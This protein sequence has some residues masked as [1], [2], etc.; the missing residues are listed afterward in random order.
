MGDA[1][2][3][4][5]APAGVRPEDLGFGVL[6]WTMRDAA[7]VGDALTGTIVLWNPAAERLFGW[8][9][10]E[11]VGRPLELLIPDHLRG[12]HRAGL[13]RFAASGRGPLVD[14]D[15]PIEVPAWH[16][17]GGD[18]TVELSLTPLAAHLTN[19]GTPR[20]VLALIRDATERRRLAAEREAVL[21]A[22][23]AAAVRLEELAGLKAAFTAMVAHELGAPVAAIRGL[24]DLL[25]RGTVP[26]AEQHALLVAIRAEA[27]LVRRLVAD[28]EIAGAVERDDFAVRPRPVPTAVLLAEAVAFARAL[29]G[30]HPVGEA[31]AEA[32]MAT[33]VIADPE[34]IGQVLRNLL[35]NA[36]KHTPAG[37]AIEL[38]AHRDEDRVWF[39]VADWGPGIPGDELE[40]VFAKFGR[41]RDAEGARTPGAGLGLYLSRRI[42]R[43]HGADLTVDSPAA[44]G[45]TFGFWLE[46][47][48]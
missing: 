24:V 12:A 22:S 41:G 11:A 47:A 45:T 4:A 14:G 44:G 9:A 30:E 42:V 23:Q 36:A 28:V 39:A 20:F 2:E 7:V 31:I 15:A 40:R 10:T 6:F 16:K 27:D 21:A 43:S 48:R 17:G 19:A 8:D 34:R 46:V 33:R 35:G 29:P 1:L 37:T 32:A 5:S 3:D 38:R 18:L 13:A 25:A 26:P